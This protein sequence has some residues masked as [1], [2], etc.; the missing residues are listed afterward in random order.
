MCKIICLAD[1][2]AEIYCSRKVIILTIHSI[3][4]IRGNIVLL[5][6]MFIHLNV[7]WL[8]NVLLWIVLMTKVLW[9]WQ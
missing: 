1:K 2:Y 3:I 4:M 5:L 9:V 7:W 8:L 6:L